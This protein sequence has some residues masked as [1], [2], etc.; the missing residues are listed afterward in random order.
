MLNQSGTSWF[1]VYTAVIWWPKA[2]DT[3]RQTHWNI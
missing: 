1:K 2:N 3:V